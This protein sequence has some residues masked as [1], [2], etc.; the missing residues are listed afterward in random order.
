MN[1]EKLVKVISDHHLCFFHEADKPV[2]SSRYYREMPRFYFILQC[3]VY[4]DKV[5]G[6]RNSLQINKRKK[7][8]I[9]Y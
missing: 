9:A 8:I 5:D 7:V 1:S 3:T 2:A 6:N 4:M